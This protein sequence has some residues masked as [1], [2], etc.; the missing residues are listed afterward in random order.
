MGFKEGISREY[1]KD[2]FER[3]DIPA[4]LNSLHK[5]EVKAGDT[6][7]IEGGVPHAIGPGC[8]LVEIQEPTDY[9]IRT[10]KITPSGLA[11]SDFMCHQGLGFDKMFDCFEYTGCSKDKVADRWRIKKKGNSVI[12]YGDTEMF[13]L[14]IYEGNDIKVSPNGVF[15]GIYVLSGKGKICGNDVRAGDQFFIPAACRPFE[16]SGN[17]KFIRFYGPKG[18]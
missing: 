13:R 12:D 4:M 2:V 17:V 6:F 18:D 14:E 9:T 15:S 10:E 8:F 16:I 11:V 1:W 3:Q 7:L 5:F